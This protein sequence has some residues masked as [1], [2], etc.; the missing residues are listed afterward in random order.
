MSQHGLER[1]D[2]RHLKR[3]WMSAP[4]PFSLRRASTTTRLKTLLIRS[5]QKIPSVKSSVI[6]S[7][8]QHIPHSW[9]IF[10][11]SFS[12][13]DLYL[14]YP[15]AV[16]LAGM[17]APSFHSG[18]LVALANHVHMPQPQLGI[19][20]PLI[21]RLPLEPCVMHLASATEWCALPTTAQLAELTLL[22]AVKH[23]VHWSC[24]SSGVK[25]LQM[26]IP[27]RQSLLP[28]RR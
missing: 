4:Y 9:E 17:T 19:S 23:F 14:T 2:Y 3:P 10:L 7:L 11:R 24:V 20:G 1:T 26:A 21:S 28:S 16:D 8:S 6:E 18:S 15:A 13:S 22:S 12:R 5:K 27:K 25:P